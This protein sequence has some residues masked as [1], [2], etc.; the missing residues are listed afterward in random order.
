MLGFPLKLLK[1]AEAKF[2]LE[3]SSLW[4]VREARYV[5]F[6]I[7]V[8]LYLLLSICLQLNFTVFGLDIMLVFV[9]Q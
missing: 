1:D 6:F 7:E 2:T 9:M 4:V 3:A 8:E 5:N